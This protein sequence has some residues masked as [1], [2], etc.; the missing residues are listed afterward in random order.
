MIENDT[1]STKQEQ[2]PLK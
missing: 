1:A 2:S